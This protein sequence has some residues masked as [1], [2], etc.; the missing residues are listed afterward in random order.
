[1][2]FAFCLFICFFAI[3]LC[4]SNS[5]EEYEKVESYFGDKDVFVS[6]DGLK[7]RIHQKLLKAHRHVVEIKEQL[8]KNWAGK[9]PSSKIGDYL[10]F[11]PPY[12]GTVFANGQNFSFSAACFR[13][14]IVHSLFFCF[15]FLFILGFMISKEQHCKG[16]ES[17]W[18]I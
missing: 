9:M 8:E 10:E 13:V 1:M 3:S 17:Q 12:L 14:T 7:T 2:K 11:I 16:R 5:G 6:K 15:F 4:K 18:R